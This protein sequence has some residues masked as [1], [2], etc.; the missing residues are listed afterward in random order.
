[1]SGSGV[2]EL[3]VAVCVGGATVAV[4]STVDSVGVTSGSDVAGLGLAVCVEGASVETTESSTVGSSPPLAAHPRKV[5]VQNVTSANVSDV[6]TNQLRPRRMNFGSSNV[7]MNV[8]AVGYG[9]E[10]AVCVLVLPHV[11]LM[12][13]R[14]FDAY[15]RNGFA[16]LQSQ[17]INIRLSKRRLAQ[18]RHPSSNGLDSVDI[19]VIQSA[20]HV[21]PSADTSFR[22]SHVI[23]SAERNLET[24]RYGCDIR[25]FTPLRSVQNDRF[26]FRMTGL[27]CAPFGMTWLRS[28]PFGM[29]WSGAHR[30]E[31][32]DREPLIVNTP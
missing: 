10:V 25:F 2:G 23:P 5:T 12:G 18:V 6:A 4:A 16:A 8:S 13:T 30:S 15:G 31:W 1:M 22:A 28:A 20:I 21:V 3:G 11:V 32:H 17:A 14:R 19:Y 7:M 9:T 27:R 29:T 24:L 26:A